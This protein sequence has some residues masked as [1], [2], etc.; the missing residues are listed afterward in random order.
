DIVQCDGYLTYWK[1]EDTR[2][3]MPSF[4]KSRVSGSNPDASIGPPKPHNV[5]IRLLDAYN[6]LP[7]GNAT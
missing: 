7:V 4:S 6:L 3:Q 1:V 5:P 2:F